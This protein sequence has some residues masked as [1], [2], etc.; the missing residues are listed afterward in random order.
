[1][2]EEDSLPTCLTVAARTRERIPMALR[3][4]TH[5]IEGVQFHPEP[6]LTEHGAGV[7][8]NFVKVIGR[9]R[10]Q[11]A[12]ISQYQPSTPRPGRG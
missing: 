5:P 3:H 4:V 7:M 10:P 12:R 9:H 11:E 6:I 8:R 2:V 1:M